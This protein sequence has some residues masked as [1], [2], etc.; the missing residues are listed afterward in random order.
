MPDLPAGALA[1]LS[2]IEPRVSTI[3][4]A[5]RAQVSPPIG[6][7]SPSGAVLTVLRLGQG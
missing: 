4:L 6:A 1:W 3:S 7:L 5:T 2:R